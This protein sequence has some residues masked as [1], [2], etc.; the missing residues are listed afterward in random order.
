VSEVYSQT[1]KIP[2][3][4]GRML[5]IEIDHNIPSGRYQVA[6]T[7]MRGGA[8]FG[9]PS[10]SA[11]LTR[12]N[13]GEH[14][15]VIIT[16]I[17]TIII[18]VGLI[19]G[20]YKRWQQVAEEAAIEPSMLVEAGRMEPK[21]IMVI[22][23]LEDNDHAQIV[24][25]LC[26]YLKDWCG[27]GE[28][29]Y[30]LDDSTG[31]H[32]G[33]RDP[34]KWAQTAYEKVKEKQGSLVFVAGPNPAISPST[35]LYPGIQENQ[36][37]LATQDM[38][39]LAQQGRVLVVRLPYSDLKTLPIE[40]PAHLANS[41]LLLPK[42]MNSFLSQLLQVKK[43]T[44]CNLIPVSL[45]QPDILPRD[46]TRTGGE[47]LL[48]K[49]R[50]LSIKEHTYRLDQA[51]LGHNTVIDRLLKSPTEEGGKGAVKPRRKEEKG[52]SQEK[53]NL[54]K[55]KSVVMDTAEEGRPVLDITLEA[56]MPSVRTL[57]ADRDKEVID[58]L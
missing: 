3:G 9:S 44:L 47:D 48:T 39:A 8:V 21:P 54:I 27:V 28:A 45:V 24:K 17:L 7:P 42:H 29:Y 2:H 15:L 55:D 50:Q 34:W 11:Y 6:V 38:R 12:P 53:E 32:C 22:T 51:A 52:A 20:V 26:S 57:P 30:P 16:A 18:T 41:A 33:Q 1:E 19:L 14:A 49:I 37:F 4:L 43:K 13:Y 40:V 36:A 10:F 31:I 25:D 23:S 46:M 35:S 58:E 56:G 5:R